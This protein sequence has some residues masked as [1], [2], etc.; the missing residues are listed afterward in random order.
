MAI[1]VTP[2]KQILN[3]YQILTSSLC[4]LDNVSNIKIPYRKN[5]VKYNTIQPLKINRS[6]AEANGIWWYSEL[7]KVFNYAQ[8]KDLIKD[9]IIHGSYGDF[10][11]TNFSD[12]EATIVV[13]EKVFFDSSK[14]IAFSNWL[15]KKFNKLIIRVDPIQH[16]GAFFLWDSLCKQY[17]EIILPLSSYNACW[18]LTGES[19]DVFS[20]DDIESI[21]KE[22]R[23][24]LEKT[25]E[26]LS[27]PWRNFFRFGFNNYAIKRY[28]SNLLLVPAFYYQSQG[29]VLNK[30]DA[31]NQFEK[32]FPC[33]YYRSIY[34][35]SVIRDSWSKPPRLLGFLRASIISK[36]I[37][38]GRFDLLLLATL[39]GRNS[40]FKENILPRMILD[41]ENLL[42]FFI[43][44]S[45]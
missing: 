31:I 3:Y 23:E 40:H 4:T 22:S 14:K 18:S 36:K 11:T 10:S 12:L 28:V 41:S 15:E 19:V 7:V 2:S 29:R 32:D 30:K 44:N 27:N 34:D 24:R 38:S 13:N 21:A 1:T 17:S 5:K 33:T 42:E 45:Q 26:N 20:Y 16:H 25:L 35:A 43:E 37:P 9:I 8:E 6:G 39:S